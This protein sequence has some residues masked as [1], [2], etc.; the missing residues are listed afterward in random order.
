MTLK[1]K[2]LLRDALMLNKSR[3][4]GNVFQK[5]VEKNSNKN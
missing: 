4:E 2:R 5:N 1:K 3:K